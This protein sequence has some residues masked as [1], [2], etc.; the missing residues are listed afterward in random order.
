MVPFENFRLQLPSAFACQGYSLTSYLHT[1]FLLA[2]SVFSLITASSATTLYYHY[3]I[4]FLLTFQSQE[5]CLSCSLYYSQTRGIYCCRNTDIILPFY[6]MHSELY[7]TG[8]LTTS[9]SH[10]IPLLVYLNVMMADEH[11]FRH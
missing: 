8:R 9:P 4:Q 2:H 10:F 3:P 1:G 5:Q 6:K 11:F 7:I